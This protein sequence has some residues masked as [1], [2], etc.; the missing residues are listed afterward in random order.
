[1][2]ERHCIIG[3]P[4]VYESREAAYLAAQKLKDE[5]IVAFLEHIYSPKGENRAVTYSEVETAIYAIRLVQM[6]PIGSIKEFKGA[7]T[8]THSE[9]WG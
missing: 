3:S 8:S 7:V 1:M 9:D 5:D 6:G 4:G 2:S